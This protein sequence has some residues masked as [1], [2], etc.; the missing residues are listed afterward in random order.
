M[1]QAYSNHHNFYATHEKNTHTQLIGVRLGHV[2]CFGQWW[3][4]KND[5]NHTEAEVLRT[6]NGSAIPL[7][8]YQSGSSVKTKGRTKSVVG[9]LASDVTPEQEIHFSFLKSVVL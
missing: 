8:L 1:G 2:T 7:S 6:I 9:K 4:G 3:L 5:V